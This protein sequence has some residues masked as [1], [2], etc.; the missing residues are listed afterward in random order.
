MLAEAIRAFKNQTFTVTLSEVIT[1]RSVCTSWRQELSR[2]LLPELCQQSGPSAEDEHLWKCP[3]PLV[4]QGLVK[5]ETWLQLTTIADSGHKVH[6]MCM[7]EAGQVCAC[8]CSCNLHA[9]C[10]AACV[11]SA[12]HSVMPGT[13]LIVKRCRR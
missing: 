3:I 4:F 10:C 6:T 2:E 11:V 7:N 8:P 1:L 12:V 13:W 5:V 9:L